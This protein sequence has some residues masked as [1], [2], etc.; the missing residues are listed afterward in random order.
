M[1]VGISSFAKRVQTATLL[2]YGFVFLLLLAGFVAYGAA[3]VV[4]SN[5]GVDAT[6]PPLIHTVR[7]VGYSLRLP[8]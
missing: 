3:A 1:V 6:D 8:R 7:G 4:D 5:R 2:A